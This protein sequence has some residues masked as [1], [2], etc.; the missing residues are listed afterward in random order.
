MDLALCFFVMCVP[1]EDILSLLAVSTAANVSIEIDNYLI[2]GLH[3]SK[4]D[5]VHIISRGL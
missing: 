3:L 1:R 4:G 5:E 2:A